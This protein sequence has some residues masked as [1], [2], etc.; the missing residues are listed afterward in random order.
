MLACTSATVKLR[1]LWCACPRRMI[2][3]Y[4]FRFRK[5]PLVAFTVNQG[6][7]SH[8]LIS[9]RFFIGLLTSC[10]APFLT[11]HPVFRLSAVAPNARTSV[12][13]V[14]PI[15]G[16]HICSPC[17]FCLAA[18][19]LWHSHFCSVMFPC[20]VL[21]L[22]RPPPTHTH[23]PHD[24]LQRFMDSTFHIEAI[25]K[26]HFCSSTSIKSRRKSVHMYVWLKCLLL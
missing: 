18:H 19:Q 20:I 7:K 6:L 14:S 4:R 13:Y 5:S 2:F 15:Y 8:L 23:T 3:P 16:C 17:L 22:Q 26:H 21:H 11:K 1:T 24:I 25:S 10:H 9:I 12:I